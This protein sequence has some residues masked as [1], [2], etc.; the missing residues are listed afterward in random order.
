MGDLKRAAVYF[1]KPPNNNTGLELT[2]MADEKL[3]ELLKTQ[4]SLTE[5]L[6][7]IKHK[8]AEA[9]RREDNDKRERLRVLNEVIGL[10]F[11]KPVQFEATE[12]KR[13]SPGFKKY[14]K[15]HGQELCAL[16]L[17][18]KVNGQ[19]KL[20]MRGKNVA[21]AYDWFLEQKIDA[22]KYRADIIPHATATISLI[23][24]VNKNGI[25]GEIIRGPH[26]QLTQGFHDNVQPS[27]F[28]FDFK[29]WYISTDDKGLLEYV[30]KLVT[31]LQVSKTKQKQLKARLPADF[32]HDYLVG[33]F[34]SYESDEFG[35]WF[36]DYSPTLGKMYADMDVATGKA[37]VG[38]VHGMAGSPGTAK[39][40]VKIVQPDEIDDGFP[41]GGVLVCAVTTPNYVPLMQKAAAIVTDQGGIL[42]HAAI[43]ARE[44]KKPCIVGTG[45]A[46]K[47]L[48]NGQFICVDANRGLVS[49]RY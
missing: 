25:Q 17:I 24:I 45:N 23:F 44:L 38:L 18:P 48:K 31:Y 43:V 30:K 26:T 20:R 33:Y 11:D 6:D 34:E 39:G 7:D 29:N 9:I 35:T 40:P 28:K 1:T 37:G 27:I 41:D 12:L 14:L 2:Y 5:W 21:G 15:E 3:A 13:Q 32:E 47:V 8:D 19:E 22:S 4:K 10:P 36:I 16:R 49:L 42:S 46:T